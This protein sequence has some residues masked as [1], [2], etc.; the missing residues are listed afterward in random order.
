M[1]GHNIL[2]YLKNV[3]LT[4]ISIPELFSTLGNWQEFANEI[5]C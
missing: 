2:E 3:S 5:W 4:L 1:Y